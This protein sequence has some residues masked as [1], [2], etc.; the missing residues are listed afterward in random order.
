M[1][2]SGA[3]GVSQVPVTPTGVSLWRE[4][5]GFFRHPHIN[6]ASITIKI[7]AFLK[8]YTSPIH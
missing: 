4:A 1:A 6:N 3:A 2:V 7:E 8:I 5:N